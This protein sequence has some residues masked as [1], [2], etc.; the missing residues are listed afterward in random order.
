ML[1]ALKQT[2]T[3]CRL[4]EALNK[5]VNT[6]ANS[7]AQYFKVDVET[8]SGPA[9]FLLL[10]CLSSFLTSCSWTVKGGGSGTAGSADRCSRQILAVEAGVKVVKVVRCC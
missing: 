6:V 5:S 2:G 9:A 1:A 3:V 10:C 7:L 8:L 4:R